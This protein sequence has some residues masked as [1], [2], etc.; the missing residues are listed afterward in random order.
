MKG[1]IQRHGD[2]ILGVLSGFD[3]MRFRGSLSLL[4][5]VGGT[6]AWLV[7]AGVLL[8]DVM[9]FAENLTRQVRQ[10][11]EKNAIA[12]GR[13]VRYLNHFVNKEA[14]VRRIRDEQGLAPNGLIAV[15]SA[16]EG[17]FSAAIFIRTFAA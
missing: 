17:C 15:L 7:R 2:K 14:L 1:F 12:A 16:L 6:L 4:T 11:T 13:P 8:K 9:K 5:T 10:A 3:R